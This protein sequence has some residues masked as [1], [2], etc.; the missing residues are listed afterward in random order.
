VLRV[1]PAEFV[2]LLSNRIYCDEARGNAV[3]QTAGLIAIVQR[4]RKVFEFVEAAGV[5]RNV[6]LMNGSA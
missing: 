2:R 1:D 3:G 5:D 6:A 4:D